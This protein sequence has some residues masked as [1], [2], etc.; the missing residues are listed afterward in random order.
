MK[1]VI[2]KLKPCGGVVEDK[3]KPILLKKW[4]GADYGIRDEGSSTMLCGADC[5][6]LICENYRG[7]GDDLIYVEIN[8]TSIL[9]LG[10]WNDGV[11]K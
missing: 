11:I 9:Y 2:K 7:G 4:L 5:V 6:T 8:K 3:L 10:R 1:P